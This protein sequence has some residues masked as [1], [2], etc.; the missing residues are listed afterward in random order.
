MPKNFLEWAQKQSYETRIKMLWGSVAVIAIVIVGVWITSIKSNLNNISGA[1][2]TQIP[3][4]NNSDIPESSIAFASVERAEV[5][6]YGLKLYLNFNNTSDDILNIPGLLDF[7]LT[8]D[9]KT[10]TPTE[11]LDRQGKNFVQKVL[12]HTQN[13]CTL[14]FPTIKADKAELVLNQMFLEQSSTKIFK[15]TLKLD[16]K[17]LEKTTN[18]R[19]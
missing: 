17:A 11:I 18:L 19:N 13:F 8:A 6:P 5:T 9:N 14:L 2:I 1:N 10:V 3:T 15:Q 16:L 4:S 12:S 7:K